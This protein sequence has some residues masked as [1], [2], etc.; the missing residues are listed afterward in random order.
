MLH[1]A[2]VDGRLSSVGLLVLVLMLLIFLT[3]C[4]LLW[5]LHTLTCAVIYMHDILD[6]KLRHLEINYP[7]SLDIFH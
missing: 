5:D 4:V 6:S 1:I 3:T 2:R 7:D